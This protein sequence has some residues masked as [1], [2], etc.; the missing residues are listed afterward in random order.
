MKP[1]YNFWLETGGQVALSIWRVRLLA[2]VSETGSISAAA[3]SMGVP[4]RIAWQKIAEMETQL[5]HKLVETQI[6]GVKGGGSRL[7]PLGQDYVERFA[8]FTEEAQAFLQNR[9]E[10]IFES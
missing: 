4:Y 3:R 5:G 7:T 9:Y 6:G 10:A 8:R 1:R 2:A